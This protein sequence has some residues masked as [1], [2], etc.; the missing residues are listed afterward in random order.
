MV[1]FNKKW[2]KCNEIKLTKK[3]DLNNRKMTNHPPSPV[4][5]LWS[6]ID[7]LGMIMPNCDAFRFITVLVMII[8]ASG[9]RYSDI[10]FIRPLMNT[11]IG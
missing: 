10:T 11:L 4:I 3:M 2:K 8:N 5:I 1:I 6:L 9:S 7:V